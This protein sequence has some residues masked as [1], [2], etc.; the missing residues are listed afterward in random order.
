[1]VCWTTGTEDETKQTYKTD[2]RDGQA[3]QNLLSGDDSEFPVL[4]LD[5]ILNH[6]G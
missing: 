1:M 6:Q 5:S 3:G 4:S 2:G